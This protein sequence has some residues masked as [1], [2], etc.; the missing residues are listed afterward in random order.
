MLEYL[1]FT[2]TSF[3]TYENIRLRVELKDDSLVY[4]TYNDLSVEKKNV[5]GKIYAGDITA[6]LSRLDGLK[7]SD[8][9]QSY[10]PTCPIL[11]GVTWFLEYKEEGKAC[12]HIHGSNVFPDLWDDFI[13]LLDELSPI[14]QQDTID[15]FEIE[16]KNNEMC[17]FFWVN[18]SNTQMPGKPVL[19]RELFVLNRYKKELSFKRFYRETLISDLRFYI[20]RFAAELFEVIKPCFDTDVEEREISE[21]ESSGIIQVRNLRRDGRRVDYVFSNNR[22]CIPENWEVFVVLLRS[23]LDSYGYVGKILGGDEF[24]Y[25]AIRGEYIYCSVEF[26]YNGR[27]YYYRT[28]DNSLRP[29]MYCL[30]GVGSDNKEKCV[31]IRKVEYFTESNLPFPL[32]RTKEIIQRVQYPEYDEDRSFD[33]L[34]EYIER[35]NTGDYGG[36]IADD[37]MGFSETT[38]HIQN[39]FINYAPLANEFADDFKLF[40][41]ENEGLGLER[42]V[43]IL[44]DVGIKCKMSSL[45]KV[46]ESNCNAITILALIMGA[47]RLDQVH[48]GTLLGFFENGCML[49]WLLRLRALEYT[50]AYPWDA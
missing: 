7:I 34:T 14:I 41:E 24:K 40:V 6:W 42:Y 27:T 13:L 22:A 39:L 33:V 45:K 15:E 20:G 17:N 30:V 11:D 10:E 16:Y 19:C 26:T 43:E 21:I 29:G 12:R 18:G 28:E 49:R 8:W 32:E 44:K 36:C 50:A 2:K 1:E 38:H 9:N 37:K 35:I 23:V 48:H 3:L 25:G 31:E 46:E 4:S 47:I 5:Q